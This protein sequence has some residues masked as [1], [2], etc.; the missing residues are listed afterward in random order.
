MLAYY[1]RH[2]TGTC[3]SARG[4]EPDATSWWSTGSTEV[5]SKQELVYET[6]VSLTS[7]PVCDAWPTRLLVELI[8]N[9]EGQSGSL[10][11]LKPSSNFLYHLLQH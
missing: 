9:E 5:I 2:A 10:K 8:N 1:L 3:P 11:H 6:F 7:F 4:S